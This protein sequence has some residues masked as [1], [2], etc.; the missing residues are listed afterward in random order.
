MSG[1]P[2]D[3]VRVVV[4]R[5]HDQAASLIEALETLSAETVSV[6]TIR[7]ED[8]PDGGLALRAGLRSLGPDDW[9]VI[10]SPNGAT[11][12]GAIVAE[13]PL[14]LGVKVAAIGPAT[15]ARAEA[16]GLTVD[17][18]P[19]E[20]IAEGL[21]ARFPARPSTGGRVL[22]ARAEV[23]RETLPLQ[24]AFMGWNV[25]DVVAYRTVH[26]DV[27]DDD[28][29]ACRSADAVAFTSGS[30][31]QSLVAAVGVEGLPP[32]VFAIGPATAEVATALGVA[33]DVVAADH[34][35]PGLVD[36]IRAHYADRP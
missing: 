22:L 10:T 23:A 25:D 7:I 33:V 1:G 32:T 28:K 18:M 2:L 3:G 19:D 4:T 35:I 24:L 36:A 30:T 14:A 6:P 21:A 12:V 29:T 31:V 16:E 8:P 11:R 26:V 15:K 13:I 34:S 5:P 20:A 17:L 27:N 9:V